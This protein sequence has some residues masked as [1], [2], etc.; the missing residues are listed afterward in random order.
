M[1][2]I[3]PVVLKPIDSHMASPL[4]QI[5]ARAEAFPMKI[6]SIRHRNVKRYS[7]KLRCSIQIKIMHKA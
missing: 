6:C 7:N 2:L 5:S 4:F 1:R 3:E